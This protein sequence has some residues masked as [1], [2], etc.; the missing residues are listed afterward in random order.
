[1]S[2]GAESDIFI[3]V[4]VEG[5]YM[6]VR[7]WRKLAYGVLHSPEQASLLPLA[8]GGVG[9]KDMRPLPFLTSCHGSSSSHAYWP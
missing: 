3:A 7:Y 9:F 6:V 2:S 8:D 1:M 4:T 5:K